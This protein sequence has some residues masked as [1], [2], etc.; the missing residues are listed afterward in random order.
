MANNPY[1][2]RSEESFGALINVADKVRQGAV[3]LILIALPIF[4]AL[5]MVIVALWGHLAFRNKNNN[6]TA[7]GFIIFV[8]GMIGIAVQLALSIPV[9]GVFGF[10]GGAGFTLDTL[11]DY[12]LY[13]ISGAVA[14]A[15]IYVM[16]ENNYH[17]LASHRYL[18]ESTPTRRERQLVEKNISALAAGEINT[19]DNLELGVVVDDVLPWRDN[20]R[21][22]IAGTSFDNLHCHGLTVG[23]TGAGKSTVVSQIVDEYVHN[24]WGIIVC[25][26]KGS[27]DLED[28][29]AATARHQG[30]PFYSFS[31]SRESSS[32][33]HM[34]PLASIPIEELPSIIKATLNLASE[35]DASYYAGQIETY[36]RNQALALSH[37]FTKIEKGESVLDWLLRTSRAEVFT[38]ELMKAAGGANKE[39]AS[40]AKQIIAAIKDV[41]KGAVGLTPHL[42]NLAVTFGQKFRPS[43]LSFNLRQAVDEGAIVF[44]NLPISGDKEAAIAL[45]TMVLRNLTNL[46]AH[47]NK[48]L[49]EGE[50]LAPLLIVA[51]EI[52]NI[53]KRADVAIELLTQGRDARMFLLTSVQSFA[54]MKDGAFADTVN[55]M[56]DLKIIMRMQDVQSALP[57]VSAFGIRY[58][59][60]ERRSSSSEFEGIGAE[61]R[62]V[63]GSG[64]G[65]IGE[66]NRIHPTEAIQLEPYTGFVHF[67]KSPG[68]T[69]LGKK[70]P[71]SRL[72]RRKRKDDIKFDIPIVRFVPKDY[73]LHTDKNDTRDVLDQSYERLMEMHGH[74]KP[75]LSKKKEAPLLDEVESAGSSAVSVDSSD[76]DVSEGAKDGGAKNEPSTNAPTSA[77]PL[78]PEP[79]Q[80]PP[81][82]AMF[83]DVEPEPTGEVE[84]Y[85]WDTHDENPVSKED[86]DDGLWH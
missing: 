53:E 37:G 27:T 47:R 49:N 13:G 1:P 26:F 8:I 29:L 19:A 79:T 77:P 18:R 28:A 46:R 66:D 22:L 55:E 64:S 34:D 39:K 71:T 48:R 42:N 24:G 50:D 51:D 83:F 80:A 54:R 65:T 7:R 43:A 2:W 82:P 74:R 72:P 75:V 6:K 5:V 70:P 16:A 31:S 33:M 60:E 17:H 52:N 59:R 61:S 84:S 10:F 76:T 14:V 41:E 40:K 78:P 56:A 25:D 9:T 69:W 20:R 12:A 32:Q 3:L 63:T 11:I 58:D 73:L 36:L 45:G 23:T 81:E 35:G 21:G 4:N 85:L 15:G 57:L 68:K 38:D 86:E 44:L 62:M 67:A 30:R